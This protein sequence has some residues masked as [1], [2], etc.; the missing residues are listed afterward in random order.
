MAKRSARGPGRRQYLAA[1]D[2]YHYFEK[3][4]DLLITGPTNTNVTDVRVILVG[5]S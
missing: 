4:G 2:S 3:L 5:R 1:N